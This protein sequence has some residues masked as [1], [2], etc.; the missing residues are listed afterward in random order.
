LIAAQLY[1]SIKREDLSEAQK[2]TISAL[3]TLAA[4]FIGGAVGG[5]LAGAAAGAQS[6]R[7]AT[8][9]NGKRSTNPT[10]KALS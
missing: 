7:N 2:Q 3:S 6:G 9:N 5:D 1:P 4:G 10:F 8:E